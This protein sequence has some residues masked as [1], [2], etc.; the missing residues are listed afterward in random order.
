M[1][2]IK[3]E[4]M[5]SITRTITIKLMPKNEAVEK[6]AAFISMGDMAKT[7]AAYFEEFQMSV[8]ITIKILNR[9]GITVDELDAIA[10]EHAPKNRPY[11][12]RNLREM[13][14]DTITKEMAVEDPEIMAIVE[15]LEAEEDKGIW[16][17]DFDDDKAGGAAAICYRQA[18]E[19][20]GKAFGDVWVIPSSKHEVLLIKDNNETPQELENMIKEVNAELLA[21]DD[22]LSSFVYHYHVGDSQIETGYRWIGR[23]AF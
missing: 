14:L 6:G 1:K 18:L 10:M 5:K 22:V 17:L 19:E 8:G 15:T 23:K 7:Y 20:I 11:R 4:V 12:L 16:I 3:D 13:I 2:N 9:W 21:T